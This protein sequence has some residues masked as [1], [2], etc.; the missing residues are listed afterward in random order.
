MRGWENLINWIF[1]LFACS[2]IGI[3]RAVRNQTFQTACT[4]VKY[5]AACTFLSIFFTQ[6][7]CLP[8]HLHPTQKMI[9]TYFVPLVQLSKYAARLRQ[10]SNRNLFDSFSFLF[11]HFYENS[12]AIHCVSPPFTIL[13]LSISVCV[14]QTTDILVACCTNYQ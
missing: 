7:S 5:R 11:L 2:I 9:N 8:N 12:P 1:S 10:L 4:R 3:L 13:L 14:M 6:V